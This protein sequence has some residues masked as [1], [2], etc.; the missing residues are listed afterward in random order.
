MIVDIEGIA[1]QNFKSWLQEWK[2]SHAD[3][4]FVDSKQVLATIDPNK[5]ASV[6]G[7]ILKRQCHEIFDPRFFFVKLYPWVP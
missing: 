7:T 1:E 3:G 2:A 5:H 4:V 6:L